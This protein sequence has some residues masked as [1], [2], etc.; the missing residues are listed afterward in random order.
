MCDSS[1]M[2]AIVLPKYTP[3]SPLPS[4][5]FDLGCGEQRLE[6]TPRSSIVA[7]R[8]TSTFT[9]K[10]GKASISLS[11]QEEGC[12]IPTYGRGG[13]ISGSLS[14]EAPDNVAEVVAIVE[15]KIQ[16]TFS[17]AGGGTL[18]IFKDRYTLWSRSPLAHDI[19][20]SSLPFAFI[21][22]TTFKHGD[23]ETPLPASYHAHF[24][25]APTLLATSIYQVQFI[26]TRSRH[27]KLEMWHKHKH[28]TI[29]FRYYPRT[30]AP[31]PILPMPCFFSSIKTSPE[32]WYQAETSLKMRADSKIDPIHCHF[33]I[34]AG[35]VYSVLD[36]IPFH[37][38]LS[39]NVSAL[40][41]LLAGPLLDRVTSADTTHSNVPPKRPTAKPL[42]QVKL[43]RRLTVNVRGT[44]YWR[45]SMLGEGSIA[46]VPP[47]ESD[48][49]EDLSTCRAGHIDWEGEVRLK[50]QNAVGSFNVANVQVQDFIILSLTPPRDRSSPMLDLNMSVPIRLVT[51]SCSEVSLDSS[52]S[53]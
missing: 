43:M 47:D 27:Q 33:F 2:S 9:R 16:T 40:R 30:R 12:S 1:S 53:L 21:L 19:F 18:K 4:Y 36:T 31:R 13:V 25:D 24:I 6:S 34:P 44:K 10:S 14:L 29:P 48:C 41:D 38:Q 26:V 45:T 11:E 22:P 49:C 7:R 35:R 28:I 5:S 8:P 52:L 17:E 51:D 42:L 3:P 50:D 39:G 20:P 32:E 23:E 46:S 37:V 15:G